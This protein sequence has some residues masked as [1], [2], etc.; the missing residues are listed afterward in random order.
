M[1]PVKRIA[2]VRIVAV[3]PYAG[4]WIETGTALKPVP[5]TAVAP[6]A[7]AW[8]ETLIPN[9]LLMPKSVAPQAEMKI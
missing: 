7:G 1:K 8:V 4:A 2:P 5:V 9:T 3:A 6:Y